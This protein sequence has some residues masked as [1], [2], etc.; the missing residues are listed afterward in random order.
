[1]SCERRIKA[2]DKLEEEGVLT[3][4]ER[5]EREEHKNAYFNLT[6]GSEHKSEN[7]SG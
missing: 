5:E 7:Y 4:T 2:L 6:I 1:M 3:K